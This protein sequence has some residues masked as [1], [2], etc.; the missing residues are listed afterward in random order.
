MSNGKHLIVVGGPTASGKTDFAIRLARHFGA[1]ILSADSRQFF[2]EMAIGTAKPTAQEL[3]RAPHHFI[4]S[5]SID[6]DYSVGD[7]E[8]DAM[9]LLEKLFRESDIAILAGGS[10]LYVKALCEGLDAFPEV[11]LAIRRQ[12]EAEYREKG[13]HHLQA[14]LQAVDPAYY[15]E[16]DLQNPHRLI[17]AIAVFRASGQPFSSFRNQKQAARPFTPIYLQLHWPR[18]ELYARIGQRVKRMMGQGLLEEARRLYPHRHHTALQTVGYQELFDYLDGRCSLEEAVVLIQRNSRRYA[19]R[20]LTWSRRDGHWKR[21]RPTAD[22]ELALR[23]I[24]A[25]RAKGLRLAY[26]GPEQPHPALPPIPG[27]ESNQWIRVIMADGAEAC[28]LMAEKK[29]EAVFLGPAVKGLP[30]DGLA[31]ELLWHEAMLAASDKKAWLISESAPPFL[32]GAKKAGWAELPA[33]VQGNPWKMEGF[34]FTCPF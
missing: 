28:L 6:A 15:E 8:R 18:A 24:E 32:R 14:E 25:A 5:L 26:S 9:Q 13:L 22:W 21:F 27:T 17:R 29:R 2:R 30:D 1:A 12:V 4:D 34:E 20:Q 23:Y 7:F 33:W 3:A 31:M 11:P 16:A 19:K 10:G